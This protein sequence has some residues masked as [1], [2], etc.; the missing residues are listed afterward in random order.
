MAGTDTTVKKLRRFSA[1]N[2]TA[3]DARGEYG[4]IIRGGALDKAPKED[5]IGAAR[6]D[7]LDAADR[8]RIR[9]QSIDAM[10]NRKEAEREGAPF[11]KGGKVKASS[12]SKRADGIAQRGKT[13]GRMV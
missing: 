12:A 2:P 11:K 1:A 9:K 3:L 5:T 6:I 7:A 4:G 13:N 8:A 10:Q